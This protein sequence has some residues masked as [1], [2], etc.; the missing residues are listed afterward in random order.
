MRG[1]ARRVQR[2]L[3]VALALNVVVA[4][5]KLVAGWRANSLAVIGDGLHSAVDAGANLVALVVLRFA[6]APADEDHPFGHG[7]YETIAAFVLSGLLLLTA[8][9]LG[10]SAVLRLFAPEETDVTLL[11]VVVM[12]VTLGVNVA[13]SWYEA[14]EGRRERS[15]ILL[16]DAAQTRADVYVTVAVLAGL[17]V[18]ALGVPYVDALLA[19]G[20]SLSIAFAGYRVYRDVMPALT[21]AAVFDPHAVARVVRTVPGVVSVHD[22]RSRGT[23][24][25]AYV[26][27]H[28]VVEPG[29]VRGAHA[30][31]DAVE[32]RLADELGVKEVLVHIEPEDDRSGPPGSR[33]EQPSRARPGKG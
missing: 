20:V 6:S 2:V 7:R 25:E 13:V 21:D 15:D 18:H 29:D 28:L 22:I 31:A 8:F 23:R 12:V 17:G 5:G 19:L 33:G 10:R 9:E 1:Y 16:A 3:L 14:R 4:A 26:Q 30:I 11:T 24:R 27:M 32:Q